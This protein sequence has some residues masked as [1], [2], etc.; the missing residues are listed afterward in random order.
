MLGDRHVHI[1]V[2]TMNSVIMFGDRRIHDT[3]NS[4]YSATTFADRHNQQNEF[5]H[6]VRWMTD[7]CVTLWFL[8][9]DTFITKH[10]ST[11]IGDK[12]MI[13]NRSNSP[14]NTFNMFKI[15]IVFKAIIIF[16]RTWLALNNLFHLFDDIFVCASRS[17]ILLQILF[18]YF[19][20][21]SW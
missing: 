6:D 19:S 21:A 3:I 8:P 11:M 5:G 2:D 14:W 15:R 4:I 17:F 12:L 20:G 1:T 7:Y 10:S 18:I 13:I 9:N 16:N